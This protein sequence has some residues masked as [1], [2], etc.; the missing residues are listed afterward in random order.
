MYLRTHRTIS[1]A[2]ALAVLAGAACV[3]YVSRAQAT[4]PQGVETVIL[5]IARF[6]D[7]DAASRLDVDPGRARDIWTARIRTKG[8][9]DVH[10]IQNTILPGGTFGWHS[11]PGPSL[12]I[13][14]S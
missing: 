10:M 2:L 14:K 3:T 7:I 13:V 12:V 4:D 9:T 8:A 11:H 6:N 5:G 1:L